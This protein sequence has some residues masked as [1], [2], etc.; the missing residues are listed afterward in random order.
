MPFVVVRRTQ[1][2]TGEAALL[3]NVYESKRRFGTK[4]L[5]PGLAL[6]KPQPDGTPVRTSLPV[7]KPVDEVKKAPPLAGGVVLSRIS[8]MVRLNAKLIGNTFGLTPPV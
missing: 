6:A 5:S 4:S 3:V 7:C 1:T 2:Q 8:L